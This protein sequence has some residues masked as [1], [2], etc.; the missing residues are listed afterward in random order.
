MKRYRLT[1]IGLCGAVVLL[2]TAALNPHDAYC[3]LTTPYRVVKQRAEAHQLRLSHAYWAELREAALAGDREAQYKVGQAI[4]NKWSAR[5]TGLEVDPE[6]SAEL[7]QKSA[8]AGYPLA[9][10][11]FW[12]IDNG[13]PEEVIAIF[14]QLADDTETSP[15]DVARLI[16]GGQVSAIAFMNCDKDLWLEWHDAYLET[17]DAHARE[18][19]RSTDELRKEVRDQ[20]AVAEAVGFFDAGCPT[21]DGQSS[22]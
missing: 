10:Y 11:H 2:T 1:V 8:D 15:T 17:L 3:V 5:R 18:T 21:F 4:A 12:Q 19:G 22:S 13:E 7:L 9:L 20:Q 16:I 14:R 6:Q